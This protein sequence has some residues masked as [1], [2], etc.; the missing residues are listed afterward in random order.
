MFSGFGG[1]DFKINGPWKYFNCKAMT[2]AAI[3]RTQMHYLF[4]VVAGQI[5][6]C[7]IW[8]NSNS[9]GKIMEETH[10]SNWMKYRAKVTGASHPAWVIMRMLGR[11]TRVLLL[12]WHFTHWAI[13]TTF[14]KWLSEFNTLIQILFS[15][16]I[17]HF[18]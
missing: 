13:T 1:K 9:R 5:Y 3:I 7:Q 2:S 6:L 8:M 18:W 16:N 14:I 10:M 15:L 17:W 12:D 11:G 4:S